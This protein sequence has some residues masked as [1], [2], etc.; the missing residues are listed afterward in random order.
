MI[1]RRR[2]QA[3]VFAAVFCGAL[4]ARLPAAWLWHW[5]GSGVPVPM[6]CVSAEGTLAS[7]VCHGVRFAVPAG[8]GLDID[9]L[10]WRLLPASLARGT[11]AFAFAVRI[12]TGHIDGQLRFG[13]HRWVVPDASGEVPLAAVAA[14]LLPSLPVHGVGG[15]L[16][17]QAHE[18]AAEYARLP[19]SGAIDLSLVDV[20]LPGGDAAVVIGDYAIDVR[21]GADSGPRVTFHS[22]SDRTLIDV[23]GEIDC[24]PATGR[25]HV[26]GEGRIRADAPADVRLYAGLL[27][28][29]ADGGPIDWATAD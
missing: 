15:R 16:S 2:I 11:A 5:V 22:A 26:T 3:L 7:G 14:P 1:I 8:P 21:A 23:Q 9:T 25:L 28:I 13:L 10:S 12:E 29:T 18:L 17:V 24:D 19:Q 6:S 27:G 4:L 20:S